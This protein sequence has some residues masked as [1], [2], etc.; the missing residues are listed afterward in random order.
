[1]SALAFVRVSANYSQRAALR[2]VTAQFAAGA[3][4]AIV[5]PNGA[6]K[7]TLFR[8]AL[9]ILYK[10][11]MEPFACSTSRLRI[12]RAKRWRERLPIFRKAPTRIGP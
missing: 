6:G 9:G 10:V 1:M 5:G 4:T 7:T 8:V 2:D 12:G 3:V 11:S